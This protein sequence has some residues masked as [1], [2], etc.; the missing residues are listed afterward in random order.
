MKQNKGITL[1]ALIVTIIILLILVAIAIVSLAGKDGLIVKVNQSK[2]AEIESE[3]KEDLT[4]VIQELQIEKEGNATI[5]DITQEWANSALESYEPIITIDASISEKKITM[6]KS[7]ITGKYIID[8]NLNITEIEDNNSSIEFYYEV[9][10]KEG[11]TVKVLIHV[12]DKENGLS[13]IELV[14]R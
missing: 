14:L 12:Q 9:G 7:G 11:N 2:H 5:D 10:E 6:F 4:I 8:K 3:M 13:R 1:V